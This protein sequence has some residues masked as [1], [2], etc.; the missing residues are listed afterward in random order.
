MMEPSTTSGRIFRLV[1][2]LI[3]PLIVGAIGGL[4]TSSSLTDWYP[5]LQKPAWTPPNW[6][7]GPVW[8]ALYLMMGF[9]AWRVWMVG[10]LNRPVRLALILFGVQ[11]ALNLGWSLLFFGLQRPLLGLVDIVVLDVVLTITLIAFLRVD[12]LAGFLL[13][14]YLMWSWFA[15]ALNSSLWWLNRS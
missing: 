13:A 9:A 2:A 15:T 4:A 8:T 7:F 5:T 14:P 3:V 1:V 6:V 12:R 11:L 10:L